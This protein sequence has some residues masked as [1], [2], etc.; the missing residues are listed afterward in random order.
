MAT[1]TTTTSAIDSSGH[2]LAIV[3]TNVIA[4]PKENIHQTSSPYRTT[5]LAQSIYDRKCADENKFGET[6]NTDTTDKRAKLAKYVP[7]CGLSLCDQ[8][9]LCKYQWYFFFVFVIFT[10]PEIVVSTSNTRAHT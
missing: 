9:M 4:T 6:T 2:D 8:V 7:T 3:S 10:Q 1:P 5:T